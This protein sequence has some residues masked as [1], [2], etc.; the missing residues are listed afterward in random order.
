MSKMKKIKCLIEVDSVE[1]ANQLLREGW[2]LLETRKEERVELEF[3]RTCLSTAV[4]F[5][6]GH[7][8]SEAAGSY[9]DLMRKRSKE[10]GKTIPEEYQDIIDKRA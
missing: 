7:N 8:Q 6:L 10:A 1:T 5:I 9:H 4:T 2:R 3:D